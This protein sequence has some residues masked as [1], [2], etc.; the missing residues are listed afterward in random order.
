M[1]ELNAF[2]LNNGPINGRQHLINHVDMLLGLGN[3]ELSGSSAGRYVLVM[4]QSGENY[5]LGTVEEMTD[6]RLQN[7]RTWLLRESLFASGWQ[8][9]YP[10]ENES[11]FLPN[12]IST[13]DD[14]TDIM[15]ACIDYWIEEEN[16]KGFAEFAGATSV[17]ALLKCWD[18][19]VVD[20]I[21]VRKRLAKG[22]LAQLPVTINSKRVM[23]TQH[24]G[25]LAWKTFSERIC[26]N[27]FVKDLLTERQN[28]ICPVCGDPLGKNIVVHHI[29]YD[30]E[31]EFCNSGWEWRIPRTKV[32]PD[33]Q[34]CHFEHPDWCANCMTRLRAVHSD[35]NFLVEGTL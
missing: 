24:Q 31:C 19:V 32:Q 15:E 29:D 14:V 33:C 10:M 30:H 5:S 27:N 6:E 4:D 21:V 2:E 12:D 28:Y 22:E 34:R 25:C 16:Y 8:Q 35:C 11:N 18:V 20:R 23:S 17:V 1:R 13:E 3:S 9:L 26:N 7:W